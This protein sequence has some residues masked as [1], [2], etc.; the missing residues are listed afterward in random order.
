MFGRKVSANRIRFE[1]DLLAEALW[2]YG[3]DELA[4]A[5]LELSDEDLIQVRLLAVWHYENDPEPASGPRLTNG[6]VV[7]RAMIEFAEGAPRDTKRQ[8]RRTRAR[9]LRYDG[10]NSAGRFTSRPLIH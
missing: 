4:A 5:A 6:R 3:E 8:R 7:A 10:G 9:D 1:R 2:Q